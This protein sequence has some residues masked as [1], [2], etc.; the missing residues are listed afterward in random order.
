M[1]SN[2]ENVSV[3]EIVPETFYTAKPPYS[4]FS[5]SIQAREQWKAMD[6]SEGCE[7]VIE[8][9]KFFLPMM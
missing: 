8:W 3:I 9:T 6:Q 7:K 5:S 2:P 1:S 4:S